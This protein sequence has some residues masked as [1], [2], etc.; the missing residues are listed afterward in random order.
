MRSLWDIA[1]APVLTAMDPA[2]VVLIGSWGDADVVATRSAT[3]PGVEVDL[4][5]GPGSPDRPRSLDALASLPPADVAVV[6]GDHNWYTVTEELELLHRAADEHDHVPPVL[7]VGNTGWPYGCRDSYQD[8]DAVPEGFRHPWRRA[9]MR[10]DVAGL[11][12][13]GGLNPQLA[14]AEHEGGAR[15][16]VRTALDDFLDDR[17]EPMRRVDLPP[18]FGLT[19]LAEQR[20]LDARP[21]LGSVL[22]GLDLDDDQRALLVRSEADRVDALATQHDTFFGGVARTDRGARRYLDLLKGALTNQHH[23][24][25]ELRLRHLHSLVGTA[26]QASDDLLRDP[27]RAQPEELRRL[28]AQRQ[29]GG[30]PEERDP[31]WPCY[32]ED[33]NG[34][35]QLEA[36]L[37]D[38]VA[39]GVPGDLVDVGIGGG[40][41]AMLLRGYLDA[42]EVVRRRVWVVDPFQAAVPGAASSDLLS[43]R[44]GFHR[45]GLLDGRVRFLQGHPIDS[46]GA[47]VA[48]GALGGLALVRIGD[49]DPGSVEPILRTLV[50]QLSPG[51]AV[52][53][54]VPPHQSAAAERVCEHLGLTTG[55][56]QGWTGSTWHRP[57]TGDGPG[58]P[59]PPAG[60]SPDARRWVPL[61]PPTATDGVDLSMVVVLYDMRREAQRT[62]FSLSRQYQDDVDDIGYEVLVVD[63]GSPPGGRLT[64][65]EVSSFG[66][67]FRLIEMGDGAPRSPVPALVRATTEARGH[68]VGLMIDG[69]HVLTPGVIA[70]ALR[71][72]RAY[73]PAV[74]ATQQF[75]LGPGQQ[76]DV[77]LQGYDQAF[78]DQLFDQIQWPSDGYRL[79]D[80]GTFIGD[81]D[82]FDGMWE[83]NCL[84]APRALLEQVGGFD[85]RFDE[86]GGGLVNLDL[87]ERL[88]SDP[89]STLVSMLG[90]GSFH[91]THG[92]TTTNQA[93][94]LERGRRLVDYRE[95][96]TALHGRPYQGPAKPV[97][98]VGRLW[99]TARRTKAR[100]L[101]APNFARAA[102]A[103]D[104]PIPMP[105]EAKTTFIETFF[106]TT[107][108]HHTHWFGHPVSRAPTD[109][110]A[111]QEILTRVRP[112]VIIS[113]DNGEHGG[114]PGYLARVCDSLDHGRVIVVGP[115]PA[116]PESH[117]RITW[118]RGQA[119]AP[120]VVDKVLGLVRAER[121]L[122]FIGRNSRQAVARTFKAYEHLVPV[123]SYIVLED[124]VVNGNPVLVEHG[125]GPMDAQR[126]LLRTHHDFVVDPGPE[127]FGL[128]FNPGGYLLRRAASS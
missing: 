46:V 105:D 17:H 120:K 43:V 2:R 8:P 52:V 44:D 32:S 99:G 113:T 57:S 124:T 70:N 38:L 86:A 25:H 67:E 112:D 24:E 13:D 40:G 88:A 51:G 37:D 90:E 47:A 82:W 109:L 75:Y 35:D 95:H 125:P 5:G 71:G 11:V 12:D 110:V 65:A 87:Y 6:D 30:H 96:F 102:S 94:I 89:S 4:L 20:V 27:A 78:E 84:F 118:V 55:R 1:I 101:A 81:R 36:C 85:E 100:L 19:I 48:Q 92:G 93:E 77:M 62:L 97:H 3:R 80:I 61:V 104:R 116:P 126:A 111:Y 127:R 115:S 68:A 15:N 64:G 42:W 9:G 123:G 76:N 59:R 16:G 21:S 28:A 10:R 91:Q 121:A 23:L 98:Y 34:L 26:R 22:D 72:L 69:A 117:D 54:D 119:Q 106:Q 7:V 66:P 53:V 103:L 18:Q 63:N 60:P 39:A 31:E 73:Q 83:S 56:R 128:T 14:N 29:T 108:W 41:S 114:L 107:G 122:V 33:R 58:A 50:P 45:F 74:V 79:F 49:I